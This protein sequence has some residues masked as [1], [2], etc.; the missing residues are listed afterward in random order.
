MPT[1]KR[2]SSEFTMLTILEYLVLNSRNTPLSKYHIATK[3]A[4]IKQQRR[5]RISGM[6]DRL[7][8]KGLVRSIATSSAVFYQVTDLGV[9]A[10]LDWVKPFLDFTRD[11]ADAHD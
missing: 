10:Y 1:N 8:S 7:E 4:G 9:K 11:A 6:M 5:D 3:V 2:F